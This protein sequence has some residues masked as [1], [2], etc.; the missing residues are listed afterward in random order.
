MRHDEIV[1]EVEVEAVFPRDSGVS[2]DARAR[3][4]PQIN[5]RFAREYWRD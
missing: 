3:P 2:L 1:G 4:S 5:V